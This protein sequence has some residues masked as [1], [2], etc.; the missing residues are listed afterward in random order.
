[1]KRVLLISV[2][3]LALSAG[4][5]FA[6][7]ASP[8][9]DSSV[10]WQL[11]NPGSVPQQ[12]G[13]SASA[14]AGNYST[15]EQIGSGNVIGNSSSL[16]STE[17]TQASNNP[18]LG[19]GV[20]QK[21][22]NPKKSNSSEIHQGSASA[23]TVSNNAAAG[24]TQITDGGNNASY[25][26]Q[27]DGGGTNAAGKGNTASVYEY[28]KGG[29]VSSKI[30]Q[31]GGQLYANVEQ[32]NIAGN[33]T[34]VNNASSYISQSGTGSSAAVIQESKGAQSTIIQSG[35]GNSYLQTSA[36][37][38]N[39]S[40]TQKGGATN[41]S[42][43]SQTNNKDGF[44]AITQN[45]TGTN[46]S[47]VIQYGSAGSVTVNQGNPG[48]SSTNTSGVYQGAV[49]SNASVV[50]NQ[51]GTNSVNTTSY[52]TQTDYSGK[53]KVYQG[54]DA[55]KATSASNNTSG[56]N[57]NGSGGQ[58]TVYQYGASTVTNMS[59]VV[60]GV[61]TTG[62]I[63]SITQSGSLGYNTSYLN[64]ESGVSAGTQQATVSQ[65]A[66]GLGYENYSYITQDGGSISSVTQTS[67]N[68]GGNWSDVTQ[69]GGQ[70]QGLSRRLRRMPQIR[71]LR[72]RP[73]QTT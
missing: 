66:N 18:T 21:L 19:L 62:A 54:E 16:T 42:G 45:S 32:G 33:Q 58:V 61:G 28:S 56:I 30:L 25:I 8:P 31:S 10:G 37:T 47:G 44:A 4:A 68:F 22:G 46:N 55:S 7:S 49:G 60:Q 63:A 9:L 17:G 53:V 51:A 67:S 2:S 1:M 70:N 24:V 39:V 43:V 52:V 36:S 35:V 23:G 72:S 34:T 12:S 3:A 11:T 20:D 38:F 14:T 59:Q 41:T 15:I 57:Q 50:I 5:A 6:G 71:P 27:D 69:S 64:Q 73:A 48:S 26:S 29:L 13:P 65:T 40:V